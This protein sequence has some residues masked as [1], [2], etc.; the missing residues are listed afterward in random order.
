MH[1]IDDPF[2]IDAATPIRIFSSRQIRRSRR[3]VHTQA[4]PFLFVDG[5]WLY[6]FF[7]VQRVGEPGYI[8]ACRTRDLTYFEPLGCVLAPSF[9][10]SYP[11]V[12]RHGVR[13]EFFWLVVTPIARSSSMMALGGCSA[14]LRS[15]SNY[16]TRTIF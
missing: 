8:E 13:F 1:A 15:G 12:F 10:V 11:Q 6:L 9:H 5:E 7:E 16:S 3:D 4:D 2:D 14:A